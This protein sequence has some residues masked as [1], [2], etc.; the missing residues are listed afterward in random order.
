MN[1]RE[2]S[3][4]GFPGATRNRNWIH[5]YWHW[6]ETRAEETM[7][8]ILFIAIFVALITLTG[9]SAEQQEDAA[10][11]METVGETVEG[12]VDE[13]AVAIDD[14]VDNAADAV[15]D[16]IDEAAE[17]VKDTAKDVGDAAKDAA[18]EAEEKARKAAEKAK[19]AAE[20]N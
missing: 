2:S 17:A 6:I 10:D 20:G 7:K 12:A 11:A 4:P 1:M 9:C 3:D 8:M 13:A 5:A 19:K 15:D 18:S 14:A 16:A